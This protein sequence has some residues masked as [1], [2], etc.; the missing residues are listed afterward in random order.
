[1]SGQLRVAPEHV[2][3]SVLDV[4]GK[5]PIGLYDEFKAIF[6]EESRRAGKKQYL[7][8]YFISAHPGS[9]LDDA[10]TLALSLKRGHFIP[11]DVQDFYPTPGTSATCMYYTGLDPRPGR[12]FAPVHVP[13]GRERRLQRAL[14][15]HHKPEN[16]S[17]V[18]EALEKAQRKEL[19]HQLLGRA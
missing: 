1:M 19:A 6:E 15:H 7:L 9:T 3:N 8:P 18:L 12:N 13:K 16:R 4:M 17:L 10:I 14:L 2:A 11:D 5:P